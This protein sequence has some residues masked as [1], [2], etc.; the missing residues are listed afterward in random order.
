MPGIKL[1]YAMNIFVQPLMLS[2]QKAGQLIEK[3]HVH[4]L[5]W[6]ERKKL[7][8]HLSICDACNAYRKQSQLLEVFI[9]KNVALE[10]L[11]L[12]DVEVEN[13]QKRVIS[14]LPGA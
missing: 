9:R 8:L 7:G 4:K 12:T 14:G 11:R 6:L 5:S 10:S 13:F 2:C 1:V 3:G